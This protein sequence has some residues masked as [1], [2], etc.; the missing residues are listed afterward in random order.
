[1]VKS[2]FLSLAML[3]PIN[4]HETTV[5]LGRDV[6]WQAVPMNDAR[7]SEAIEYVTSSGFEGPA[8]VSPN[9]GFQDSPVYF[10][11][12]IKNKTINQDFV[13]EVGYPLLDEI[14]LYILRKHEVQGPIESGD[15]R[16]F[17]QRYRSF[18]TPNF[19]IKIKPN[20][21]IILVSRVKT[22][23]SLPFPLTLHTEEA[24]AWRVLSDNFGL[25]LY[26]GLML[27]MIVFNSFLFI[28]LRDRIY[29]Y[30]VGYLFSFFIWQMTFNGSFLQF[31]S[32]N[33]PKIVSLLT[34]TCHFAVLTFGI[35]FINSFLALRHREKLLARIFSILAIFTAVMAAAPSLIP[36]HVHSRIA[37]ISGIIIPILI[38]YTGLR[39]LRKGF[40][41]ARFFVLAWGA[42]ILG[43]VIYGLKSLGFFPHMFWTE[44]SIK[45]GSAMEVMLLSL[46]LGDRIR[47][48]RAERDK[49]NEEM[50][51][52]YEE[53][54]AE[55]QRRTALEDKNQ[56]LKKDIQ[57]ATEE[58]VQAEKFA[59]LGQLVAGVANEISRPTELIRAL[60][61]R[62][63]TS[64]AA[65]DH[66][67][68]QLI[69]DANDPNA[70]KVTSIFRRDFDSLNRSTED[71]KV[72][73]DRITAIHSAIRNQSRIDTE[74][75]DVPVKPIIEE[76]LTILRS[77]LKV[78]QVQVDCPD[79]LQVACQRSQIGQVLTNL[80]SNA[81]DA[82]RELNSQGN[83]GGSQ[84]D[85]IIR[86]GRQ[87]HS[88]HGGSLVFIEVEDN[89]PGV[90]IP[91][92]GQ[93]FK[94][95][96]TTKG[97]GVGTGLGLSLSRKIIESHNGHIF[98]I[99]PRSLQGACFR[100]ELAR[101]DEKKVS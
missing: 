14:D 74:L 60:N 86:A 79:N 36:Y 17:S 39:S 24:F 99:S 15:L 31:I 38:L 42:F 61:E 3:T 52:G 11:S 70:T 21:D 69:S 30:Y 16:P 4:I 93:I 87:R 96:F 35:A 85:L 7:L 88:D 50:I 37:A 75:N 90:S 19:S 34:M 64:V 48:L 84:P 8:Q 57:V 59:T 45:L 13:L 76:C 29:L 91:D 94:P 47:L 68:S 55:V 27:V 10:F 2:M 49:S 53:L 72:A 9:L 23:G 92:S 77:R 32:P 12:R 73:L 41:P 100:I 82:L 46:A 25:G 62:T 54:N 95:L 18:R 43:S 26:Y 101:T 66:R 83:S 89:G 51:K 67:L 22:A 80:I 44:S 20:E 81:M 97:V 28:S 6:V 33:H 58:L 71:T 78:W 63:A 65:I 1:M 56:D 40:K 98:L 5:D